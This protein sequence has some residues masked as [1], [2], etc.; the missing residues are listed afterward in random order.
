MVG[1]SRYKA[2]KSIKDKVWAR[3]N[4]W[5][6]KFLSQADKEILIKAIVQVIPT[7]S[8]SV[9]LL[10]ISLCKELNVLI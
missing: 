9:F 8:M 3:L 1:R 7:Y 6:V 5:K 10:L 4:Y 2:F